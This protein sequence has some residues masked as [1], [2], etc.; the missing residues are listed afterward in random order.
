MKFRTGAVA[1]GLIGLAVLGACQTVG[2]YVNPEGAEMRRGLTVAEV[3]CAEC[4]AIGRTGASP[5]ATAPAFGDIQNRYGRLGLERE[6]EAIGEVGHYE[7]RPVQID[8]ADQ[9][10]LVA[11][12]MGL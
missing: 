4:H 10:D 6:M 12:I 11:Y 2:D 9:R 1:L 5:R 7:M 3:Y 8:P